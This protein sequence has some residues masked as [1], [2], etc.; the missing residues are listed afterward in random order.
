MRVA[1]LLVLLLSTTF[2]AK[3]QENP[4]D[5]FVLPDSWVVLPQ[6]DWSRRIDRH[7]LLPVLE[8]I[9]EARLLGKGG[10]S[11]LIDPAG[12]VVEYEGAEA[13]YSRSEAVSLVKAGFLDFCS[14]YMLAY[15]QE[16]V[17]RYRAEGLP[18]DFEALTERS[19]G[20]DLNCPA[21]GE[22]LEYHYFSTTEGPA[23]ALLCAAHGQYVHH[24][25]DEVHRMDIAEQRKP[26][27]PAPGSLQ[28]KPS[29]ESTE[30]L[31]EKTLLRSDFWVLT[32]P[33]GASKSL[34]RE[35]L[36]QFLAG[37]TTGRVTYLLSSSVTTLHWRGEN[38]EMQGEDG[39]RVTLGRQ[40]LAQ[41][42]AQ[43]ESQ[44]DL[45]QCADNL[46]TLSF[47]ISFFHEKN[48]K[49]PEK[50]SEIPK[51]ILSRVPSCQAA[52]LDTYSKSYQATGRTFIIYCSGRHHAHANFP[53]YDQ[54]N[55]LTLKP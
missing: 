41:G 47:A 42:T 12:I 20:N 8:S 44:S 28:P 31:L 16:F 22:P 43:A 4:S 21:S 2:A 38:L 30:G 11:L 15:M 27:V 54:K 23:C 51:S 36:S 40:E 10:V 1:L 45:E 46:E 24:G 32:P 37:P 6:D 29:D 25:R 3:A 19:W 53:R 34:T 52:G 7:E 9:P 26:P 17:D 18:R 49:Y 35:E 39:K 55:G 33:V 48:E 14:A 5:L 50:L 13:R